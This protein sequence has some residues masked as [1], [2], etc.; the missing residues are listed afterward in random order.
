MQNKTRG[1]N[2]NLVIL[3]SAFVPN[4]LTTA[5]G[6][7]FNRH[8]EVARDA[9]DPFLHGLVICG[10]V[11]VVSIGIMQYRKSEG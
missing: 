6:T 10:L 8:N 2:R 4:F 7:L 1:L 5:N 3:I 9:L 11:I